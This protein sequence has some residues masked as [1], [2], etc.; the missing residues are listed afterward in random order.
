[1][2][3]YLPLFKSSVYFKRRLLNGV[4]ILFRQSRWNIRA[5]ILF[6]L[7][8]KTFNL[9]AGYVDSGDKICPK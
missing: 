1:M 7:L 8:R 5:I 3:L 6:R 2:A 4:F 9:I